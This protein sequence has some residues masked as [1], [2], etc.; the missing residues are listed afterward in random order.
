[1]TLLR[2]ALIL[3]ALNL[4]AGIRLTQASAPVFTAPYAAAYAGPLDV[5]INEIAWAGTA[6]SPS[7]EWIELKNNTDHA[8]DLTGWTLSSTSD[9][10]PFVNLSGIIAPGGYFLLERTDNRTVKDVDADQIYSGSLKNSGE[11]LRLQDASGTVVDEANGDGGGWPAGRAGSGAPPYASMERTDPLSAGGDENW[12]TNDGV[13]RNGI[14][15][16]GEPINGTP[17]QPNSPP[18]SPPSTAS[19]MATSTPTA[20]GSP[21]ATGTATGTATATPSPT[22]TATALA[23]RRGGCPPGRSLGARDSKALAS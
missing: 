2:L 21:T 8:V 10:T 22:A 3:G 14:D 7:D 18:P 11:K 6:A 15:A 9:G 17:R 16:A 12:H 1:M 20:T 13:T 23:V 5:V 4:P 19:A